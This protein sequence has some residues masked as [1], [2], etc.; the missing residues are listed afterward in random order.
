MIETIEETLKVTI[1]SNSHRPSF[2]S[3]L[4]D[5]EI[6]NEISKKSRFLDFWPQYLVQ[7]RLQKCFEQA[8]L[9]QAVLECFVKAVKD[10]EIGFH[11]RGH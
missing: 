5:K 1:T 11:A 2:D 3:S 4:R 10:F 7:R 8:V 9:E 6:S